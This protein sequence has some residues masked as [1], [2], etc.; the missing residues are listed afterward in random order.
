MTSFN[1]IVAQEGSRQ[2][3]AV[4]VSFQ[5]LGALKLLYVDIWCRWGRSLLRRGPA[6]ARAL[7]TRFNVEI[8][9]DRVVSFTRVATLWR[10]AQNLRTKKLSRTEMSVQYCRFGRWYA[11][12]M[13]RHLRQVE[14]DPERDCF[15]GFNSNCLEAME[16]LKQRGVFTVLDQVD[17][18]LV[19]ENIVLEEAERWPS[20]EGIPG[21]MSQD[22][23]DRVKAEWA[24]ADLV[25][26]NSNW[27]REAL[28][29]QGV[30][31]E[32]IIVVPLAI[33][34]RK[35]HMLKA[36]HPEGPLKVLWL[37]S[38]ILRKGIQYL[39]EA[40]RKLERQKVEFLL[41]G[42]LGISEHAVRSFPGNV[43]VIG[44]VTRDQLGDCYR[45]AHLFVLPTLSDGFAVT[46]LEAMA[47]GLPVVTTP[48]C[49]NVVTEGVDGF[50]VPARDSQALADAIAR[51]DACRPLLAEMSHNALQTVRRFDLPS[52]AKLIDALVLE[53]R[54][55][56]VAA[57]PLSRSPVVDVF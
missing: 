44:R 35:E 34:L 20:W 50:I 5:R 17:P 54:R 38:V 25:L 22:Y 36:I 31:F 51:L 3:Y 49:G 33:D 55:A 57:A 21:R 39:V 7:A 15:F 12:Q 29:R 26:V 42:P 18:G 37:G 8:P 40:A 43:K 45:Q 16:T 11:L 23:W 41:A 47:H 10:A 48:N 1:W 4:P 13:R 27:S 52:N 32:K 56:L 53:R 19:E 28:T 14:I 6:A 2:T 9:L 24:A 30:P 46:Q